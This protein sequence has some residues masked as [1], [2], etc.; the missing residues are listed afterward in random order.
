MFDVFVE[1]RSTENLTAIGAR[2]CDWTIVLGQISLYTYVLATRVKSI[3]SVQKVDA[4]SEITVA[5]PLEP[6]C[7]WYPFRLISI[8]S[9]HENF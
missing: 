4:S 2:T 3:K 9:L 8:G 5:G 6:P 1:T 7:E